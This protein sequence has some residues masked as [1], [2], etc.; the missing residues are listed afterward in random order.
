MLAVLASAVVAAGVSAQGS[1]ECYVGLVVEAGGSCTYPGTDVEFRVDDSGSGSLLF[2]TS[3]QRLE[4]RAT[5]I[6]G[7]EYTFVASRQPGGGWLIEEVGGS[8]SATTS[9]T[10]APARSGV[11]ASGAFSDVGGSIHEAAITTLAADGVFAGTECAPGEFCPDDAVERWVMAVWL[12]RVLDGADPAVVGSSRFVDVDPSEWWAPYVERL[13]DLGVTEGCATE[14]ARFCPTGT[15][16]RAQMASFLVRAFDLPA[17]PPAGFADVERGNVHAADINALAASGVTV[18][19]KT[20]PLSYCPG[21]NTT[22]AE[23]TT[24]VN[25]ALTAAALPGEGV[26]IVAGRAN[27]PQGYFQ[28]EVYKLLLEELGYTVSDPA[29][30]ELDPSLAYI[31]M[32]R[33]EMDFWPNGW[34][35]GHLSW[36]RAELPDGSL[37]GDHISI[38]G[39][40]LLAGG[41]QGFLVSKSFADEYDVYTMDELNRHAEA[42]AAF[43]ATDPIP[44][45]G[46]ADIYGCPESWICDDIIENMIAFSGWDNIAQTKAGYDAMF[47]QAADS[48]NEGIPMVVYTWTPSAYITQLRP[49]DNVYWMGVE[50]ILDD[51]NPADQPNGEAH[52]QRM[53][54]GSGGFARLSADQCPSAADQPSGQCKI[55][56]VATDILVTA[57]NDFLATNPAARALFEEV[58]LTVID[59]SEAH[60]AVSEGRSPTDVAVEWIAANRDLV[61]EWIATALSPSTADQANRPPSLTS[62]AT[63]T[64]PTAQYEWSGPEIV[65]TWDTVTGADYYN[66]YYDDFFDSLCKVSRGSARF[67]DEL[68]TN[69]AATTYTHTNPDP[70]RN[71][72]WVTACNSSGCSPVDS[73]KPA[74]AT[75]TPPTTPETPPTTTGTPSVTASGLAEWEGSSIVLT[76]DTVTGADYYNIYYDDFFDSRC[77]V[78]S[79]SARFC[80]ELATNVAATT[81]TH[82]NPNPR[83]NNYY[84][85]VACDSSEC[86]SVDSHNPVRVP[87]AEGSPSFVGIPSVGV[88]AV[89]SDSVTLLIS[90]NSIGSASGVVFEISR[91]KTERTGYRIVESSASKGTYEDTNRSADTLYY[92]VVRACRDDVCS[93]Y[94]SSVGGITEAAGTVQ[95]PARLTGLD[96]ER[97]DIRLAFDDARIR[98]DPVPGAT[99][100]E[101]FQGDRLDKKV[102]APLTNY[103]DG[104]PNSSLF[105]FSPTTYTVRACNKAGCSPASSPIT[106]T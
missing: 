80:D 63:I 70:D 27:W 56:W 21:H 106:I 55:G 23:M 65:L 57:N 20:T 36:H 16:T 74:T 18:G 44:G 29:D 2:F 3:G 98:W 89:S 39:K 54:D 62:P 13:A 66:I 50:N 104:K 4:L 78:S 101:V 24:F 45:N 88:D 72:Y 75:G 48:A 90:P 77:K 15:V 22:R 61:D 10:T 30:L 47:A 60:V 97:V 7:V 86:A 11:D 12:V 19:C 102:F 103:Y 96:G 58:K 87:S 73:S 99:F 33:G 92:Y 105:G 59:V 35:P 69:V 67:C 38:V 76:W 84:W 51:S 53:A 34:Y 32:A 71:Y 43:D 46:V 68:A 41:L 42:L 6:N 91:S 5:S 79:G 82:T 14:P 26:D 83:R 64:T 8:G 93:G 94:S 25:R 49:G 85:L 17:A 28:A 31:A 52:S 40:M 1:E 81:Y 100:Y 95:I 9:S 37:V